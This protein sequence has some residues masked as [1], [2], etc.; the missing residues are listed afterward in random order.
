MVLRA[1]PGAIVTVTAPAGV[2]V[3]AL[4]QK[5]KKKKG[6]ASFS[7]SLRVPWADLLKLRPAKP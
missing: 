3:G 1:K 7:L 4:S 5:K 2:L 6:R